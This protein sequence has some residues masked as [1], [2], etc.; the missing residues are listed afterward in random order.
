MDA[1]SRDWIGILTD[2]WVRGRSFGLSLRILPLLGFCCV[3]SAAC[4]NDPYEP[5]PVPVVQLLQ[6]EATLGV[7]DSVGLSLL[8]MLPPG[9]V[10]P[11]T[12]SSSNPAVAAVDSPMNSMCWVKGMSP[13]QATILVS[14]EGKSDSATVVVSP[15]GGD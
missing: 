7:G 8:P 3:S 1:G 2:R 12:W 4:G 14:G 5:G 13:G 11:V 6:H 10:P 9:Y 15:P